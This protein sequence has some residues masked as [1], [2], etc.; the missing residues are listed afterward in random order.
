MRSH[1][2]LADLAE[3][4]FGVVSFR[5]LRGLGFSKGAISR[6]S[7]A[8]RL[9]RIHRGVYAVGHAK[10][11]GQGRCVAAVLACGDGALVSHWSAAWLWG[12]WSS[13]PKP[14]EISIPSHGHRRRGV[15]THHVPSLDAGER[16][17]ANDVIPV[18]SFAR[19]VLDVAGTT[20]VPRTES[21]LERAERRDL[22][23]LGA[24]DAILD[25]HPRAPGTGRL[26]QATEIYRD[27]AFSR[28][29]SERL[30]KALIKKAGLPQPVL[31]TFVAG[32]EI[33]AYWEAEQFAV[34]VDG[35]DTHRTRAAF[36]RDPVRQEDLLLAGI[37]CIRIT[38]RRIER[39]PDAVGARLAQHLSQRQKRPTA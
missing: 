23:D 7:E 20:A 21:I 28:A 26:R 6:M 31:N 12:L 24:I 13:F 14:V 39:E 9:R 34:E 10:L 8:D 22:L 16:A 38:A 1:E 30:F 4:Q 27:P 36:E 32:H 5:Q 2:G 25:R 35:W 15:W 17:L 37:T 33:D 11:S 29:R 19:T 18:T 3:R